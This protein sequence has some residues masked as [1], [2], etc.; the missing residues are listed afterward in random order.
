MKEFLIV[1]DEESNR[2]MSLIEDILD[3]S[4]MESGAVR[5][6]RTSCNMNEIVSIAANELEKNFESKH[7]TLQAQ[8]PPTEVKVRAERDLMKQLVINLLHNASK[9]TPEGGKVWVTVED[10]VVSARI[11]VEDNGIGIP[12][13]QIEKIFDHFH[14]ADGG[15]HAPA[16]RH[17]HRAGHLQEHRGMARRP[18]LG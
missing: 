4:Q 16:R 5:F 7:I 14:Q 18:H 13:D 11:I 6:E 10:E 8:L 17:G 15:V 1:I 9:F 12:E 3:F 2:L